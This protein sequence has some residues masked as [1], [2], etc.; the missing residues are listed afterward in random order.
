MCSGVHEREG[1]HAFGQCWPRAELDAF[2]SRRDLASL[3]FERGE[4]R[5]SLV[6][7]LPERRVGQAT[8]EVAYDQA[9]KGRVAR[10]RTEGAV[11][12]KTRRAGRG[13]A[14]VDGS[15]IGVCARIGL[16]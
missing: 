7:H 13:R 14:G 6:D 2:V 8:G 12:T 9:E 3:L 4:L 15:G 1:A 16:L 10:A 11:K 5:R